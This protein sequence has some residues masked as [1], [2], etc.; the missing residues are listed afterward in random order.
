MKPT[1][2]KTS[3][4]K[5]AVM[6]A[7]ERL[8]AARGFKSTSLR[9]ITAAARANLGAVNYHFA[10]KDALILAVLERRLKPL[11]ERCTAL[12]EE[13]LRKAPDGRLSVEKILEAM[14]RPRL[15]LIVKQSLGGRNF[16]RLTAFVLAEPGK[17]LKPLLEE[18][19]SEKN[20]LFH[21][22][23]RRALPGL[24]ESEAFWKM[25]FSYGAFMHTISHPHILEILSHGLCRLTD[26]DKTLA[27]IIE[28]CAAGFRSGTKTGVKKIK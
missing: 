18:Q 11:N 26:T 22:A 25:H 13:F 17:F 20:R 12:L 4:T 16:Q 7:A 24:S 6:N 1:Q 8:F 2:E 14:F 10:S 23:L 9:A 19:F 15:E 21:A 5:I 27:M 3:S 28:F